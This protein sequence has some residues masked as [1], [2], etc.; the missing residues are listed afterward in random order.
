MKDIEPDPDLIL[1]KY[2]L[3]TL[4]FYLTGD[5]NLACRHCWISPSYQRMAVSQ[6]GLDYDLFTAIIGE[7]QPLGLVSVKLTGGEPL[8]H[9]R[10][11]DILS[12]IRQGGL[13]LTIESNGIALTPEI[14]SSIASSKNPFLS[15]SLDGSDAAT[16]EW[17]RGVPG[18]FDSALKGI[19]TAVDAG[20]KPQIILTLMRRNVSQIE[21]LIDLAERLG[22]DSVKINVLQPTA[23]GK[24]LHDQG[25]NLTI[26]ELVS[27]GSRI[28]QEIGEETSLPVIFGHPHAF[29]PMGRMFQGNGSC[30]TCQ[31]HHI[32]GVLHEGSYALCGIGET[33]P[34]MVFG[35]AGHDRLFDVW[36]R[37]TI[38]Q[39]IRNGVPDALHGVCRQCLMKN[40]CL[41]SCIA[42]N[43]VFSRDLLAPYWYCEEAAV[44]GLFPS[45]RFIPIRE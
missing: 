35:H 6:S 37:N 4:Y 31:V 13:G 11:A 42:L 43:Y 14:A 19:R 23:R 28:E 27:I 38:L 5:C 24:S 7:A 25:E 22:A 41:G 32:L 2:P 45:S 18:S 26:E 34:E 8:I 36:V 10:I 39:K 33:V 30:G 12:F 29:R 21:A 44:K 40:L 9:P 15:I 1:T 17:I 20:I 16:H 3:Q